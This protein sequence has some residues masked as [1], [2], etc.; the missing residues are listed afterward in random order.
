MNHFIAKKKRTNNTFYK[1]LTSLTPIYNIPDNLNNPVTFDNNHNLNE[2]A[3]FGISNFSTSEHSIELIHQIFNTTAFNSIGTN[4]YQN[5]KYFC[6]YQNE[7]Y[8]CFQSFNKSSVIS[9]KYFNLT[10]NPVIKTDEPILIIKQVPDAIYVKSEDVLY[11]KKLADIKNIFP[12]TVNLYI[13]ATAT[14]T[15]AFLSNDFI[16]LTNE[17][18]TTKVKSANRKR[19]SMAIATLNSL[20]SEQK[21][22]IKEYTSEYFPN[23]NF[24]TELGSFE[25][26]DEESL[27][28]LIF[29]IEQRFYTT[30]VGGEKRVANSIHTLPQ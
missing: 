15:S 7:N 18:D 30:I 22:Q 17:Y 14:E 10:G 13:E 16:R 20:N 11:F 9:R 5:V 29:G 24:D 2:D 19:V 26:G 6:A 28:N 27:K 25:I 4:D 12:T 1:V 3:W 8:Y 21:N 23:L